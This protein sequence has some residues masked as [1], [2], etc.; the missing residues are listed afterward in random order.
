MFLVSVFFF[1]GN[2]NGCEINTDHWFPFKAAGHYG[3]GSVRDPDAPW[4]N[5][6][7][8]RWRVLHQQSPIVTPNQ[9]RSGCTKFFQIT[10]L[11]FC[12]FNIWGPEFPMT[13]AFLNPP[14][15][16]KP[17]FFLFLYNM[18]TF[19]WTIWWVYWHIVERERETHTLLRTT[20]IPIVS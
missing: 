16:P 4:K 12:C 15:L 1:K 18:V 2:S 10:W 7:K 8:N 13:F 19:H 11:K 20:V 6:S 5:C 17:Y 3:E 14:L 9:V